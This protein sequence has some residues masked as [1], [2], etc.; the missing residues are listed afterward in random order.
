MVSTNTQ[1]IDRLII[2][3]T[4]SRRRLEAWLL[5]VP[6]GSGGCPGRIAELGVVAVAEEAV[7]TPVVSI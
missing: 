3:S 5:I 6:N 4:Q 2:K 1:V 7:R